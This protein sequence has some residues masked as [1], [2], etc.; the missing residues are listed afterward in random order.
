MKKLL[1]FL[2]ILFI[3][4]VYSTNSFGWV[5]VVVVTGNRTKET[6]IHTD[7]QEIYKHSLGILIGKEIRN[8][9]IVDAF[10]WD[11]NI[12]VICIKGGKF[13]KM[14]APV[15]DMKEVRGEGW[16]KGNWDVDIT[17]EV[18]DIFLGEDSGETIQK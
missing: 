12:N 15:E 16:T 8:C 10:Y 18:V 1:K 5:P 3:M 17:K 9:K 11:H 13:F 6:A 4:L 7:G 2:A 14:K